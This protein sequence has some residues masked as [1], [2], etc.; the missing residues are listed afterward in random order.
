MMIL[1]TSQ[2]SALCLALFSGIPAYALN[3]FDCLRELMPIT[4]R[5]VLQKKRK[6]FEEPFPVNTKY[7]VFPEVGGGNVVGFYVYD[8]ENAWY[9]DSV[10]QDKTPAGSRQTAIENLTF[11]GAKGMLELVAQPNGL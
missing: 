4:D 10:E 3:R 1:K 9:Y 6:G 5:A 8:R 2:L 7:L 11:D